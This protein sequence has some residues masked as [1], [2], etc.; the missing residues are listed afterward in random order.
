MTICENTYINI[1]FGDIKSIV[2]EL[3][4]K[5]LVSYKESALEMCSESIIKNEM[6]KAKYYQ[7]LAHLFELNIMTHKVCEV[8]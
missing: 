5:T 7:C 1:F 6:D 4:L 3:D 8:M 2:R